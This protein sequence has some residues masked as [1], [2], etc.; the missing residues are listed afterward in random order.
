MSRAL[1]RSTSVVGGFTLVSRVLGLV[2]D[3]TLAAFLAVGPALDAFFIA[4]KIPN[5]MRRLFAEGSFSL[6]FVPVFAEVRAGGDK[7]AMRDLVDHV[8]GTLAGILLALTALGVI[9][10]LEVLRVC[11][12][13][14][15]R[16]SSIV[17]AAL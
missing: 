12:D 5:F 8:T 7:R 14:D 3:I 2:R 15:A 16:Q 1:L 13:S 6:A 9:A 11:R 4:F 10:A 17:D